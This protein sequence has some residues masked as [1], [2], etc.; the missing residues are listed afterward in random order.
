MKEIVF[1]YKILLLFLIISNYNHSL[2]VLLKWP[3]NGIQLYSIGAILD[4]MV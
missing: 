2:V 1:L 4:L 3:T